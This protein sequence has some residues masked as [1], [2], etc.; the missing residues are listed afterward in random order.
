MKSFVC[1][2][3]FF[4]QQIEKYARQCL[5]EGIRNVDELIITPQSDLY[6][7]LNTHY[8][9]SNQITVSSNIS[10]EKKK[11]FF[12]PIGICQ[13]PSSFCTAVQMALREF[14]LAIQQEKDFESSWKKSIYKVMGRL[15]DQL[16]D[17][18]KNDHW[19]HSI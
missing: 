7:T 1:S 8:N 14:F 16:P 9:R 10:D 19:M 12:S 17:F 15:D 18:F 4:Y 3:E 5:T 2:R 13:V 6:R 11:Q